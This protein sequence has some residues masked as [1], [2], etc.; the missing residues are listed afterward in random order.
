VESLPVAEVARRDLAT[1]LEPILI[2]AIGTFLLIEHGE[3]LG[4]VA[5]IDKG[6]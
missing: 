4:I 5:I 1:M 2:E 6:P 3:R